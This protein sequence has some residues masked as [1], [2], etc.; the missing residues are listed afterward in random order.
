VQNYHYGFIF[1]SA[2]FD[3]GFSLAYIQSCSKM[4]VIA[5]VNVQMSAYAH[6]YGRQPKTRAEAYYVLVNPTAISCQFLNLNQSMR[7]Y[8]LS[9]QKNM[10]LL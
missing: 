4:S 8:K 7:G 2:C 10:V 1:D 5:T 6:G 9:C 3:I